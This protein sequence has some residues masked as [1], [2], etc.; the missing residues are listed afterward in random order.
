[1]AQTLLNQF[2]KTNGNYPTTDFRTLGWVHYTKKQWWSSPILYI[3]EYFGEDLKRLGLHEVVRTTCYGM[4]VSMPNFYT[5]FE[6]YYPAFGTFFTPI[7]EL[8]LV[9]H[10]MWEVS[11]LPLHSLPYEEYFPDTEELE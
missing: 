8:G 4:K 5:I 9:F 6:L 2:V 10:E 7:G 3:L 11:Y 1:M